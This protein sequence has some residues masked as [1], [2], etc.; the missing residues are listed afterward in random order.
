[1]PLFVYS[2]TH[3]ASLLSEIFGD[4]VEVFKQ[5]TYY[6]SPSFLFHLNL[7]IHFNIISDSVRIFRGLN[8]FLSSIFSPK[9]NLQ[10]EIPN[11]AAFML[12]YF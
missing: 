2:V 4:P 7:S 8:V 5:K 1:M 3:K 6:I 9:T 11:Q 12:Q 10:L